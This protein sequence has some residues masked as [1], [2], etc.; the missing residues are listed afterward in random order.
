MVRFA[1]AALSIAFLGQCGTS[2]PEAADAV[3]E[4][5]TRPNIVFL[6]TDDQ[7]AWTTGH[8]GN[9]DAHTPN[10][11]RIFREGAHL[12]NSFTTTPV[13]SPSVPR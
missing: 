10:L 4:E 5:T 6:Y 3:L 13:C 8:S 12:T 2:Q 9:T 7:G 1:L 11:D